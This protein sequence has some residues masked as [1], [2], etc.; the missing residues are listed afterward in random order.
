[1]EKQMNKKLA[2]GI[3]SLLSAFTLAACAGNNDGETSKNEPAQKE[4]MEMDHSNMQHS[5]S[6]EVPEGL[7]IAENPQ[8]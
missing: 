3:M 7:K 2:I 8:P 4:T 6:A 5:S 1:V